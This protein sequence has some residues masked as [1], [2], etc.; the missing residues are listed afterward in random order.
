MI[1]TWYTV[2]PLFNL[3]N[4]AFQAWSGQEGSIDVIT[5]KTT[6]IYTDKNNSHTVKNKQVSFAKTNSAEIADTWTWEVSVTVYI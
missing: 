5:K 1:I 3:V 2:Y 6:T 4:L